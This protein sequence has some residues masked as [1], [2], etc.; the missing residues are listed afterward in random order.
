M[1]KTSLARLSCVLTL[2]FS[3]GFAVT[4]A[5]AATKDKVTTKS[6][7]TSKVVV[8][9]QN[10]DGTPLRSVRLTSLM[11]DEE[12]FD[13]ELSP[14][15]S[16][17]A[18]APAPNC[19]RI[20][21]SNSG[22]P[23]YT[24]STESYGSLPPTSPQPLPESSSP[25]SDPNSVFSQNQ[26]PSQMPAPVTSLA[27]GQGASSAL[28]QVPAFMGDFFGGAGQ[29]ISN[30]PNTFSS[31]FSLGSPVSIANSTGVGIMKLAENTS[32]LPRDRVFFSYNHF[33]NLNLG[34]GGISVDRY[35]PGFE[36]TF[37]N[38]NMSVEVRVPMATTLG[39][40]TTLDSRTDTPIYNTNQY[41]LGNVTT[42]FK[43][44]LYRD[45]QFALSTGIGV[46]APTADD[47]RVL[48][49]KG[50]TLALIRNQAWHVLPY[51]GS[52]YT[53]ND[54][55]FAQSML[56]LDFATNGN[57]VSTTPDGS[58]NLHQD[59]TLRDPSY[60]FASVG[61]GYWIYQSA[62]PTA[63]LSRVSLISEFHLNSTL[64]STNVV[65][66]PALTTGN[67]QRQIQT[68]NAVVGS[69]IMFGQNK[70]LLLGYVVPIGTDSDKAFSGEFR[71]LFNWYFGAPQTNAT[72]VQ[73]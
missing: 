21:D 44:L 58:S 66:G 7:G 25:L 68:Q 9:A 26:Q 31:P 22:I 4:E 17:D 51:V 43:G 67:Y 16:Q 33:S 40:N 60:L 69:N 27:A 30:T 3:A 47:T 13:R 63:R 36:K 10:T 29:T 59:G 53:P 57:A 18:C 28:S 39:S 70:S 12:I 55:W 14:V 49:S 35:T 2:V 45:E 34:P 15:S 11:S 24:G 23:G 65:H 46:A 56:Q 71:V 64:Q 62:D 32:P 5:D 42:F 38:R 48:D 54:R 61:T 41:Q 52:V 50:N 1:K 8:R 72:R 37:F 20:P 73:F 19:S 6:N